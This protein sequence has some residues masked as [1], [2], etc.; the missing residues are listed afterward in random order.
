MLDQYIP[1]HNAPYTPPPS[2]GTGIMLI[3]AGGVV[4]LAGAAMMFEQRRSKEAEGSFGGSWVAGLGAT[5]AACGVGLLLIRVWSVQS[6]TDGLH[7]AGQQ[8]IDQS[9][10]AAQECATSSPEPP[11]Y[12]PGFGGGPGSYMTPPPCAADPRDA[13]TGPS[14]RTIVGTSVYSTEL[15]DSYATT[16]RIQVTDVESKQSVCVTVPATAS[17]PG[18]IADGP[19]PD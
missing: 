5:A 12:V 17:D 15:T 2:I 11:I 14:L 10:S 16:G 19:C 1:S 3:A 4:L 7:A 18:S 8:V 9:V 13:A 6:R